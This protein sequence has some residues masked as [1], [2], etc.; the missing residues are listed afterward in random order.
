MNNVV[1]IDFRRHSRKETVVGYPA[2]QVANALIKA[3]NYSLSPMKLQKLMYF[4]D[5]W[6]LALTGYKLINEKFEAWE[7]GPV[8]RH[9]YEEF[10]AFGGREIDKTTATQPEEIH[11]EGTVRL[12]NT[13]LEKYGSYSAITLSQ[14]THEKDSPWDISWK[15]GKNTVISPEEMKSYFSKMTDHG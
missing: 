1:E 9:V 5:G 14:M 6:V 12:I 11:E 10:S 3:S 15:K 13:I 7:Y 2:M 8:I 4:A